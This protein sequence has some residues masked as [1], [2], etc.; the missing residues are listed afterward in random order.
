MTSRQTG[1]EARGEITELLLKI[2]KIQEQQCLQSTG[3]QKNEGAHSLQYLTTFAVDL[4]KLINIAYERTNLS[5]E[6]L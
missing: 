6:S 5:K 4:A 2:Q 3:L 1:T